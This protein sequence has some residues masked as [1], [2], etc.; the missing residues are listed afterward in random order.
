[1]GTYI[2]RTCTED[3]SPENPRYVS[4]YR[5]PSVSYVLLGEPGAGKT[6]CFIEEARQQACEYVVARKFARAKNLD[7]WINKTLFID[8][9]D[10]MRAGGGDGRIPL[11]DICSKLTELRN[12]PFRISCREADWL[13][14]IDQQELISLAPERALRVLRLQP[15]S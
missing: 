14:A 8:G 13:G 12:P 1:M 11:E 5:A 7:Q 9:L 10:E 15:L 2:S 6:E 4:D 3:E